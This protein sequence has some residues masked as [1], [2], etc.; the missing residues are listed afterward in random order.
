MHTG[1]ASITSESNNRRSSIRSLHTPACRRTLRTPRP[2]RIAGTGTYCC[3]LMSQP[4]V[5]VVGA[6]PAG[7]V[8][9]VTLG[10]YA[11]PT[12][13][14]EKRTEIST[15]SRAT[16]ISTRSMEIFRS[17][18]LED[19]VQ[20]GAADVEPFG[21]V[22]ST[23]ASGEGGVIR[24]GYPSRA[25]AAAVS[26]T[27]PAWAPQD[28]LEPLLLR[29]LQE[30]TKAHVRFGCELVELE[31]LDGRV[32]ASVRD[33]AT[34][35]IERLQ[36]RYVVGAD[37]AHS[38]VRDAL[39]IA[40]SGADALAEFQMV[41]FEAPLRHVLGEH[42]FGLNIVTHP[43]APGVFVRRGRY[44][45]WGYAREVRDGQ[46]RLDEC[47]EH[48]LVELI[49]TAAGFPVRPRI[50]RV[51][52]FRFAA[53]I[54]DRY[55][56]RLCFLVGDAAH[57]MTPRGGTG[58]NTAI[59]DAYDLGWKLAFVLRGWAGSELLDTYEDE[60]RPIGLHNV[61]RSADP[62]GGEKQADEAL[63]WD[64]NGRLPHRWLDRNGQSTSILDLLGDGL[65]LLA[66][67]G[68]P[69][70]RVV[71]PVDTAAPVTV[72]ALDESTATELGL[73]PRGAVLLRPD[74]QELLRISTPATTRFAWQVRGV[75]G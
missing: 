59:Q 31:Q 38:A 50:E 3:L 14:I 53:Q 73:A 55:R 29:L 45:R 44:D 20:A 17:W 15:L 48:R 56:D 57:R 75:W 11:V 23:L 37:G 21:W 4:Q 9:A 62:N 40:M 6:G 43:A 7:L 66:R 26:P 30:T 54:A 35:N 70:W 33:R 72:A 16:V 12:V 63:A 47:P 19:A 34:E 5:L 41:Q 64:L 1:L 36:V 8:A 71:R 68:E 22:T 27:R 49:A 2:R 13:L 52:T 42:R 28:H 60:R 67:S 65:T 46:E 51:S 58:M 69:G 10:R 32:T 74:G 61:T 25:E 39:G 18:G 24:L